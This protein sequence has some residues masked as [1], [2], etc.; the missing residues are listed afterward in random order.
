MTF[1]QNLTSYFSQHFF[2]SLFMLPDLVG[3][4]IGTSA[5]NLVLSDGS[6]QATEAHKIQS[7][8]V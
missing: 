3:K 5:C 6:L 4:A 1:D 8:I 2:L 7:E